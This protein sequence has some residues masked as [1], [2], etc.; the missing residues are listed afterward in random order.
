MPIFHRAISLLAPLSLLLATIEACSSSPPEAAEETDSTKQDLYGLGSIGTKWPNGIVPVCFQNTSDRPDLQAL[1][2]STLTSSWQTAANITFTGFGACA[3]SGNQATVVFEALGGGGYTGG[4][5]TVHLSN[6]TTTARFTAVATHEFG[7]VLGFAHEMQRPDNFVGGV[8]QQCTGTTGDYAEALGGV[9][10]TANYDPDSIMNYC[11]DGNAGAP[12]LSAADILGVSSPSGYGTQPSCVFQSAVAACTATTGSTFE[13]TFTVPSGCPVPWDAWVLQVNSGGV[14][15]NVQSSCAN[16]QPAGTCGTA[17][18]PTSF[19]LGSQG[20]YG[21]TGA[22]AGSVQ[23]VRMCGA[24]GNCGAAFNLT[25]PTCNLF[26]ISPGNNPLQVVQGGN[27][28]ANLLL[29]GPWVNSD[30]GQNS[31]AQVVNNPNS[32]TVTFSFSPGFPSVDPGTA[33][34]PLTV[35]ATY[36]APVGTYNVTMSGRDPASGVTVLTTFPIEVLACTPNS[37]VCPSGAC[38]PRSNGCGQ[39]T[40]CGGCPSGESCSSGWCVSNTPPP[41]PPPPTCPPKTPYC[42]ATGTCMTVVGCQRAS[43]GGTCK[44]GTC[45]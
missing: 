39:Q 19:A 6:N 29:Y 8:Q 2:Q 24:N 1:V 40:D 3:A 22:A 15:T 4:N 33:W 12:T 32:S 23:T 31:T 43:G 30:Q 34:I 7:H 45:S 16:G 36:S 14:W 13:T 10:L 27:T 11:A 20:G 42:D 17:T 18:S 44:P 35:N 9:Y 26:Y 21:A 25:I 38:G 28:E 41:P 5:Y 37:P